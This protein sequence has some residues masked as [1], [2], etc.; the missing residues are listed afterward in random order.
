MYWGLTIVPVSLVL[1]RGLLLV[2]DDLATHASGETLLE[3]SLSTTIKC[4]SSNNFE[5]L[6]QGGTADAHTLFGS[7][8]HLVRMGH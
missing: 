3:S 6:S 7:R 1:A 4:W 8:T 2:A 5:I